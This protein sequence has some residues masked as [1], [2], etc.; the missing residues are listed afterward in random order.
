M[1][2]A[3]HPRSPIARR[4]D[5]ITSAEAAAWITSSGFRDSQAGRVLEAVI[6]WPRCTSA[7]LAR[8]AGLDRYVVARR[9]SELRRLGLIKQGP[10]STCSVTGRHSLTWDPGV[11]VEQMNLFAG[12]GPT[13]TS[14]LSTGTG[15]GSLMATTPSIDRVSRLLRERNQ[16]ARLLSHYITENDALKKRVTALS[17]EV[18]RLKRR[19]AA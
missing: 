11:D 10:V 8:R 14:D 1:S 19:A 15:T 9:L 5:P 6:C 7:E 12:F 13:K 18:N 3:I 4:G 16:Q 17:R 2:T